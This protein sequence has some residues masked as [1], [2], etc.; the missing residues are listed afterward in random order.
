MTRQFP[1]DTDY[2][3]TK[4]LFEHKAE[5]AHSYVSQVNKATN[6]LFILF[7]WK[8][9]KNDNPFQVYINWGQR[10][11][12]ALPFDNGPDWRTFITYIGDLELED[13]RCALYALFYADKTQ[14]SQ[15][16]YS[17]PPGY[18]YFLRDDFFAL[19]SYMDVDLPV[20]SLP[21]YYTKKMI[22]TVFSDLKNNYTLNNS[23]PIK[24]TTIYLRKDDLTYLTLDL[25][26]I[27]KKIYTYNRT[28]DKWFGYV[29]QPNRKDHFL[30]YDEYQKADGT[31][32]QTVRIS[33]WNSETKK[34]EIK[35][36][37][38]ELQTEYE[39][40]VLEEVYK[41]NQLVY[42]CLVTAGYLEI[43]D[44]I[45]R[46]Y[47]NTDW[48]LRNDLAN[49]FVKLDVFQFGVQTI[50]QKIG[51]F[52][53]EMFSKLIKYINDI[54]TSFATKF[55]KLKQDIMV[56]GKPVYWYPNSRNV[57]SRSDYW[58]PLYDLFNFGLT[59]L[60]VDFD[61][62]FNK[63]YKWLY[64]PMEV[65]SVNNLLIVN[66]D[67]EQSNSVQIQSENNEYIVD[68]RKIIT[69]TQIE[70]D[71]LGNKYMFNIQQFF[72]Y[73]MEHYYRR[74]YDSNDTGV[75]DYRPLDIYA[76]AF[77]LVP[78]IQENNI[79]AFLQSDVQKIVQFISNEGISYTTQEELRNYLKDYQYIVP[80][81][82]YFE[83]IWEMFTLPD[84]INR[85]A[86]SKC[87]ICRAFED[88]NTQSVM[89]YTFTPGMTEDDIFNSSYVMIELYL[90]VKPITDLIENY[91]QLIRFSSLIL[92]APSTN[93]S[94]T[95]QDEDHRP[96]ILKG[97]ALTNN[98]LKTADLVNLVNNSIEKTLYK[99]Y[100]FV[101]KDLT[102]DEIVRFPRLEFD[103]TGVPYTEAPE[104]EILDMQNIGQNEYLEY[105]NRIDNLE[106]Q[107]ALVFKTT[108][109]KCITEITTLSDGYTVYQLECYDQEELQ[110]FYNTFSVFFNFENDLGESL[111]T[112]SDNEWFYNALER[113]NTDDEKQA[114]TKRITRGRMQLVESESSEIVLTPTDTII[115]LDKDFHVIVN[116]LD[117]SY[118]YYKT[119]R[120]FLSP[121]I[122]Y[123][124]YKYMYWQVMGDLI[125]KFM[126]GLS[127]YISDIRIY[128][129]APNYFTYM[130]AGEKTNSSVPG[131]I[132]SHYN[133]EDND[134]LN[135]YI[136]SE[137][138]N[139]TI[140]SIE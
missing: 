43:K 79:L 87:R 102:T 56:P 25:P 130:Y 15:W 109:E 81:I 115:N 103:F 80:S 78:A 16:V 97:H 26:E 44:D 54:L 17:F 62:Y 76:A 68:G 52:N 48:C 12:F 8:I 41:Y 57:S 128:R 64:S 120:G 63:G 123:S 116:K 19:E 18:I 31:N 132:M 92:V 9:F 118:S 129:K 24:S 5:D 58:K 22:E 35:N 67:K 74:E 3:T 137:L 124:G 85:Y 75:N 138:S 53:Q 30:S 33:E 66:D 38:V 83:R 95:E 139:V 99:V 89:N 117:S 84:T 94:E 13:R 127:P 88:V 98:T 42:E 47:A 136:S 2:Y 96:W 111:K 60:A 91:D 122:E 126:E 86:V 59:T 29:L 34:Q 11:Y 110:K 112:L 140:F 4:D 55:D 20:E 45:N 70:T 14:D 72:Y 106:Y 108:C 100:M 101:F 121:K 125:D 93:Y 119:E 77:D 10:Y 46:I 134:T 32:I 23:E 73:L 71:Y 107:M 51:E 131:I 82:S 113:L 133:R 105:I 40:T 1:G 61:E 104:S 135:G 69:T 49:M 114:F 27:V 90:S 6:D 50:V 65:G 39:S 21:D 7:A 36:A 37:C 28:W